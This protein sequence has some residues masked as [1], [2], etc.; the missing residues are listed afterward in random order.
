MPKE[1]FEDRNELI[2]EKALLAFH[3]VKRTPEHHVGKQVGQ[4]SGIY[5][6]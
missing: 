6:K 4:F 5:P 2:R 3:G 1:Q